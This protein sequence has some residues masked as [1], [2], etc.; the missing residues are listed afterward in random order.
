MDKNEFITLWAKD[1]NSEG[2]YGYMSVNL[3]HIVYVAMGEKDFIISLANGEKLLA[4][5]DE[6][7]NLDSLP[8]DKRIA[9]KYDPYD[10]SMLGEK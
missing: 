9:R 6:Y 10:T 1:Y 3:N 7:V 8:V 2:A 5:Y 4:F